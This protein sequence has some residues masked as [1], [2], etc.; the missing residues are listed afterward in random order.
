M[1]G[2]LL[3]AILP[4]AKTVGKGLLET[5]APGVLGTIGNVISSSINPTPANVNKDVP[6]TEGTVMKEP[7][8][9]MA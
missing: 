9:T 5:F 2:G 7:P 6:Y 8:V 4:V 3:K 1:F